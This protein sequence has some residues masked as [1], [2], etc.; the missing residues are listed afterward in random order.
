M[1]SG[2]NLHQDTAHADGLGSYARAIHE[3]LNVGTY[4][5][6]SVLLPMVDQPNNDLEEVVGSLVPLARD[7]FVWKTEGD[8]ERKGDLLGTWDVWHLI[9]SVCKYSQRLCVGKN[10]S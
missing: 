6:M 5:S 1:V 4:F 9:R 7:E 3:A 10:Q 8:G 2:P